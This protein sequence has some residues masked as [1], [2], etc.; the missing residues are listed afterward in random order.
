MI[1]SYQPSTLIDEQI[2][3]LSTLSTEMASPDADPSSFLD[4]RLQIID[5][6][7]THMWNSDDNAGIVWMRTLFEP[8][9]AR[10]SA[11]AIPQLQR[12]DDSAILCAEQ[13]GNPAILAPLLDQ[14]G[15]NLHKQG[16]HQEAIN[17]F[18]NATEQYR[19][20]EN[21]YQ[22]LRSFYMT[23]SC[24]RAIGDVKRAQTVLDYVFRQ[25]DPND[26]WLGNPLQVQGWIQR[27]AG[28]LDEAESSFRQ[29]IELQRRLDASNTSQRKLDN[30]DILVAGTLADLGEIA[31]LQ[32]RNKEA[33]DF[34]KQSLELFNKY[35]GQY[36]RHIARSSLKLAEVLMFDN[37]HS[38][39]QRLLNEANDRICASNE[40]AK[41]AG[42]YYDV[43]WR[44]ELLHGLIYIQLGELNKGLRKWR[45][46]WR[47][48][49][50][51]GLTTAFL[52][53]QIFTRLGATLMHQ[54][55]SGD[56]S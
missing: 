51:L 34:L 44:L 21:E 36:N 52:L 33:Q 7:L 11:I 43:L 32:G 40:S 16:F 29:A 37:Q 2:H 41:G 9:I 8:L 3:A 35:G 31:G 1:V 42:H 45:S 18:D 14:R 27:N 15:R 39:A 19:I 54:K 4:E 56:L 48:R 10:D 20:C 13:I 47:Y 28:L 55:S 26:P 22:A 53:R 5:D 24:H 25:T 50:K 23:A 6:A 30:S 49:Q 38:A 17:F 12:L 46:A